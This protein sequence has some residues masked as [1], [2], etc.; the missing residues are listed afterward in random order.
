MLVG[1]FKNICNKGKRQRGVMGSWRTSLLPVFYFPG[2]ITNNVPSL[3]SLSIRLT[4][5][6]L[7]RK[8]LW[9]GAYFDITCSPEV[10]YLFCKIH[11]FFQIFFFFFV[12]LSLALSFSVII[13]SL[14]Y[15]CMNVWIDVHM[16]MCMLVSMDVYACK[17]GC[18]LCLICVYGCVSMRGYIYAWNIRICVCV[19]MYIYVSIYFVH[20]YEIFEGS[21][22]WGFYTLA[23]L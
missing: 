15:V 18:D 14:L 13:R 3:H 19:C 11:F 7:H 5:W 22:L 10:G 8:R 21:G 6:N 9:G 2:A 4:T 17:H 1:S 12:F 16:Y 20:W 23:N